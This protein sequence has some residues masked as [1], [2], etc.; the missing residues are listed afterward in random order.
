M[1]GYIKKVLANNAHP[2]PT[3][4]KHTPRQPEPIICG[5][6]QPPSPSDNSKDRTKE[7]KL[8]FQYCTMHA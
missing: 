2:K 4:K 8:V 5:S 3:S 7:E 6:R 1:P